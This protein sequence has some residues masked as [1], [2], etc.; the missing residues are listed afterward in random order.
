MGITR[1]GKFA[2]LVGAYKGLR[3]SGFDTGGLELLRGFC[4]RVYSFFHPKCLRVLRFAELETLMVKFLCN[5]IDY[6]FPKGEI[7][8]RNHH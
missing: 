8:V 7:N 6:K 4:L 1:A 3:C 2:G 5:Q